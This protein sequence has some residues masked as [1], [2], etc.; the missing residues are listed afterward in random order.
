MKDR[1][2][3]GKRVESMHKIDAKLMCKDE[4]YHSHKKKNSL[5]TRVVYLRF[6]LFSTTNLD[7]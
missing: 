6:L 5:E 7:I 4:W 1:D 2:D 3:W